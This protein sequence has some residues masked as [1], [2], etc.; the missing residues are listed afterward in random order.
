M[1][2]AKQTTT[3]RKTDNCKGRSRF[4]RCSTPASEDRSPGTPDA[5]RNDK[6]K[7]QTTTEILAFDKLRPE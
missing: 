6:Q 1:T 5:L 4:L 2:S 7:E 3:K